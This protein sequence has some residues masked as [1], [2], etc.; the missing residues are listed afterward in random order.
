[1]PAFCTSNMSDAC[2]DCCTWFQSLSSSLWPFHRWLPPPFVLPVP[3]LPSEFSLILVAPFCSLFPLSPLFPSLPLSLCKS[4]CPFSF[5]H[6]ISLS[7]IIL[8]YR[9]HGFQTSILHGVE[10]LRMM[11][12]DKK[13]S[14]VVKKGTS[15]FTLIR[16]L[17]RH[18]PS[19]FI[20]YIEKNSSI[21]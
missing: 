13:V 20:P 8:P 6:L 17:K 9:F 12:F 18:L 5:I 7:Y 21:A 14:C 3:Y 11:A 10:L 1:M 4:L 16:T 15:A 2:H 19:V